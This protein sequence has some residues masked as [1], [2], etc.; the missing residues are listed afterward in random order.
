MRTVLF[1][2]VR[3]TV[4]LLLSCAVLACMLACAQLV[5]AVQSALPEGRETDAAICGASLY[6]GIA[7]VTAMVHSSYAVREYAD[8]AQFFERGTPS[9]L[10]AFGIGLLL[11]CVWPVWFAISLALPAAQ[12]A[13]AV[14][15]AAEVRALYGRGPRL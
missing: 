10:S 8:M 9:E 12:W 7:C 15:R 6:G 11:S 5:I 4:I 3:C 13:D 2:C 1:L 14:I